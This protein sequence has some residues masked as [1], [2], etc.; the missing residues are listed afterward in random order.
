[1]TSLPEPSS[2]ATRLLSKPLLTLAFVLGLAACGGGDPEF[3][4][5]PTEPNSGGGEQSSEGQSSEPGTSAP[6]TDSS[7]PG[8]SGNQSSSEQGE[9]PV[10]V[11]TY[12]VE[13]AAHLYQ[14]Q[15]A[16]CHGDSGT[17]GM[18]GEL[19]T[20]STC[21]NTTVLTRRIEDTMPLAEPAQCGHEC[22]TL[23]AHYIQGGF[24][25][26]TSGGE[27][28][29]DA[30]SASS[31]HNASSESS[32]ASSVIA[33]PPQQ[34]SSTATS[35]PA[36]PPSSSASSVAQP[37]SSAPSQ[38]SSSAEAASSSQADASSSQATSST[39]NRSS[40]QSQSSSQG[41]SSSQG[42]S[43]A[44]S[45]S[46]SQSSSSSSLGNSSSQSSQ[47]SSDT[48][49][50]S[51]SEARSS[52]SS[53]A[54][55]SSSAPVGNVAAG[56]THY[57]DS[58]T[59][60]HGESGNGF[61]FLDAAKEEYWHS[62]GDNPQPLA[63][64]IADWMPE[65]GANACTGSCAEDVAAY[66]RSWTD[67]SGASSASSASIPGNPSSSAAS[68]TSSAASVSSAGSAS[69][70]HSVSS[71]GGASSMAS[72]ASSAAQSSA[73]SQS[74][75]Q[76]NSSS[77]S[78]SQPSTG[79]PSDCDVAYGPR[80]IRVLT[81][82]EYVNSVRDLTGV[83][84]RSDLGRSV[85][86]ALPA[87]NK[88]N[89]F[90]N[91][92]MASIE[93][94]SLQSYSLVASR[95]ADF[96]AERD[97]EGVID[98][99]GMEAA[100]CGANLVDD[101]GFRVFRRPLTDSER[102]AFQE[103][104]TAEYTGGDVKEG[105]K[106]AIRTMLTSPNF[107]YRSETGIS[108]NDL[109]NGNTEPQYEPA[110]E[111]TTFIDDTAP[112]TITIYGQSGHGIQ[113]TGDNLLEV[114][115]RGTQGEQGLWPTMRIGTNE[116][117][118]ATVLVDHS[119]DKTYR[120]RVEALTG[121]HYTAVANQQVGAD[122][123]Y[124]GGHDLIVSRF[125]ASG[126]RLVE[127]ELPAA[128][129][130]S[131]AYVLTPY[132]LA[133]FL[134]FTFTGSTP[135]LELLQAARSGELSNRAQ[136]EAQ[137]ERLLDTP[138]AREKFGDFAAQWLR[139]D[140]VI[141]QI[142]DPELY[143][144]FT[145]E[146]REAMVQEVR[147][148][149]N[150]VV[151]DEGEPFTALY[152]GDFTFVN[153]ALA[154]F[155]GLSGVSGDQL[156]KVT[157]VGSRAGLVTSG[158]FLTVNAHERETAPILRST[159]ARRAFL[160]HDVPAP[161][162][163]ISL[164]GEDVDAVREEQIAAWEAYL[165]ANGGLATSRK[166]YEF[167]TSAPLCQTCHEEMINPLGGGFEDFDA[168]GMPQT[169]DYNNL[170]VEFDGVLHGVTSVNDGREISFEGAK[171]FAHAIAGLDVTRQCFIDN[172]FRLALG[173]GSKHFD[174]AIP[175]ITLSSEER[176]SYSCEAQQLDQIMTESDNSTRA[177]LKAIGG[178]DSV[179]YRKNVNR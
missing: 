68:S 163:G 62:S 145:T 26:P 148:I 121:Q 178:M 15:C 139:A 154:A 106:L 179:R 81:Q 59:N 115:V 131:D 40:A 39:Q 60:C 28:S 132:E 41:N 34:S 94:G 54:S 55:S 107:L 37:S 130:D 79:L 80:T 33:P 36:T 75:T 105:L 20:C 142:K 5:Q 111:V 46:R 63:Q 35:E 122:R 175:S 136:I 88:V 110:G 2:S 101:F 166:K 173:T 158:A 7:G 74:S 14:T 49:H 123:E 43:S 22:S 146:V 27:Q 8:D 85:Y 17:G 174:Y 162:T 70:A 82:Q 84:V 129:L 155:Y 120:F 69:S 118:I 114:V 29:S 77:A 51:S 67:S 76:G 171:E 109:E 78:S 96:L 23:L 168:V 93:S 58:C 16:S 112:E 143:P 164:S 56:R 135:D 116:Q 103:M 134:A 138:Q 53:E 144:Q 6:P 141:D 151:L 9:P 170:I 50:S 108:V 11:P 125:Q 99:S 73:S 52:S 119:Y 140:R 65:G 86:D 44:Q 32:S 38:N 3:N 160:C 167:Q 169:V 91:N 159:Y 66:I 90:S 165:E 147:A 177:L 57:I 21:D 124:E 45:N 150:H 104:F 89:G 87:D 176:S 72:S 95:I 149:F 157:G 30:S 126:V 97:F 1:M 156:Q 152:D 31:A 117:E 18:G 19:R 128:P 4:D 113:Y 133:S 48:A 42:A 161:P 10:A 127:P 61:F 98:C 172:M 25:E 12:D 92:V 137:V 83:D 24:P 100:Q 13:A 71:A 47:Q 102:I 64:Y 153:N